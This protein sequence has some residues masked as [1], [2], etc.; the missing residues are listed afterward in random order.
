MSGIIG[1]VQFDGQPLDRGL[2]QQLTNFLSFRG[3]DAQRIWT[4]HN[5]G[6]GHTLFK[7][8]DESERDCQPLSLDSK[9]W[10]VA[11]ARI[12][13]R[14][15]LFTALRAAGEADLERSDCTDAELILRA[16]RCWGADCVERLLGDFAFGIWDNSRQQL[17]CARDHMGVKPFYYAQVG[18]SVIFSNTLDCIRRHPL[19][20]DELNGLAVAD[21][22]LF[23]CNQDP[24]S[25]AFTEIQRLPPA[26]CALWSQAGLQLSRYWSLPIDEP[27]SYDS[28]DEYIDHFRDLMRKSVADRLRTNRVWVFMSGGM[29]SPTLAA[30]ARV[31]LRQRDTNF[32]L[33][34]LTY[35]D[36]FVP[37]EER[38]AGIVARHLEIPIEYYRWMN[39]T[40]FDWERI[41]FSLPEPDPDA[42]FVPSERRFWSRRASYGRVFLYGEGPDNALMLDWGPYVHSLAKNGRYGLLFRSALTTL[43]SDPRP[44]FWGRISKR[45]NIGRYLAN[46]AEPDYPKSLN[47]RFES[48]LQL[49][50][51]WNAHNPAAVR[52]K[53]IQRALH[54]I[55]PRA[56]ASLQTPLWPAMFEALDFGVSKSS[57]EVRHPFLDIRMLRFLLAVP[58]LPWCRSKYLLRRAMRGSLP[59]QILRRKKAP[60]EMRLLRSFLAKFCEAPFLLGAHVREYIDSEKLAIPPPLVDVQGHL[61]GRCLNH[62]LQNLDCSPHNLGEVRDDRFAKPA[63]PTA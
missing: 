56:Y 33:R 27:L 41:P 53:S 49:R 23:G 3:P 26:N 30:A 38:Y 51:R 45:L 63:A 25:T 60:I 1:V 46:Y 29:D 55:R 43:L 19:V 6:F 9:A 59:N 52:A 14:E 18:A 24:T 7:T 50:E 4:N 12:D 31:L 5:A 16:Y 44:P 37:E 34:A 32:D 11:D 36:S 48:S 13:A 54:P 58:P 8:T 17:F 47:P 57:Y 22:L 21:F 10:I 61:R 35:V 28:P 15:D 40:E 62:W 20:S 2:L 42:Y 39:A